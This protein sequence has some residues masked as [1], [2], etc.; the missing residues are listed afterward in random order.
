MR[1]SGIPISVNG[2]TPKCFDID[3]FWGWFIIEESAKLQNP[4]SLDK[5]IVLE[6]S[7]NGEK[8]DIETAFDRIQKDWDQM[9]QERDLYRDLLQ[10]IVRAESDKKTAMEEAMDHFKDKE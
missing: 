2:Q 5:G 3:S 6:F 10:Q 4:K 8:L 7:I 9:K 1:L